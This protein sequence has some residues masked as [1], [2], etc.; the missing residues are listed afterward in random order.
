MHAD[1]GAGMWDGG[2]VTFD[3]DDESDP[4]PY[5]VPANPPRRLLGPGHVRRDDEDGALG[6][7]PLPARTPRAA[8]RA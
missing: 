2:P 7:H 1:F 8:A 4:G 3:Y 5:P 6:H